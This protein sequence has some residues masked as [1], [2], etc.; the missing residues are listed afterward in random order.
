M[1]MPMIFIIVLS[2]VFLSL[3]S[4]LN[5]NYD[6]ESLSNVQQL[7]ALQP[8]QFLYIDGRKTYLGQASPIYIINLPT[9]V[10]RRTDSIAV[11]KTLDLQAILVPAYSIDS[12][13][14]VRRYYRRPVYFKLPEFACWASHMRLWMTIVNNTLQS[15]N[16]TWSLIFEDDI[17][18]E[19]NIFNIVQSFP[20]MIWHRADLIY[21]GH[22]ANPPGQ[23][24]YQSLEYKYRIHEA[25]HPS[26]THAYAIRS[27]SAAKLIYLLSEPQ[28]PI[29]DSIVELV[30]NNRLV[31]FS[32]HPPLAI[33]RLVSNDNPSDVNRIDRHSWFY[34]I[35]HSMYTWLQWVN[36]V[37]F[38]EQLTQSTLQRANRTV[39][40]QWRAMNEHTVWIHHQ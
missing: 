34:R 36:G 23:M 33:Q 19:W 7:P 25:R 22:C 37:E 10:D 5:M 3:Y 30:Q 32:I 28:R 8:N 4:L 2:I 15:I 13:E 6:Y 26:C 31:V 18:L 38:G 20:D 9:R 40:N 14:I 39:A 21:L 11:I 12:V 24:I 27:A 16:T 17:D 1:R 35:Q 29:D